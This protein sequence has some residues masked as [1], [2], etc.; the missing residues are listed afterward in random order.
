MT[1]QNTPKRHTG[2]SLAVD[3]SVLLF[4]KVAV[5]SPFRIWNATLQNFK[6][7]AFSYVSPNCALHEVSIGR[8]CSIGNNVEILS[9]HAT[10][11]L[12]TSPFPY[13]SVFAAPFN[14][15]AKLSFPN[16]LPTRIG[17]DVWIGA[18]VRIK[19]GV[20]I[21][22]GAIIGAGSVVTKDVEPFSVVAG[23][24]ARTIR[25]RFP[26]EVV[27]KIE[28]IEWWRFDLVGLD[29]PFHD[30]IESMNALENMLSAGQITPYVS[31][32]F[33]LWTEGQQIKAEK[34]G[35]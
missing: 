11:G 30:P 34:I 10:D 6:G 25:M 5:E 15:P 7:G 28:R 3:S 18:G 14:D 4:G 32:L 33:R 22:N 8:Y 13:Q 23:V 19:T 31:A 26:K 1:E 20:T 17:H 35:S 12:T 2:V 21:G 9:R 16:L 29:M 27:Q 24:P